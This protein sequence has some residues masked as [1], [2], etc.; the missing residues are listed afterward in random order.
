MKTYKIKIEL[1][2][3]QA[4]ELI[5]GGSVGLK[6]EEIDTLKGLLGEGR[7]SCDNTD[8]K[9]PNSTDI[10]EVVMKREFEGGK[11]MWCKNCIKRDND[12]IDPDSEKGFITC[13]SCEMKSPEPTEDGECPNC[14]SGN[15]IWGDFGE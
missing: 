14:R 1:T 12:M 3:A 11:V 4:T 8:C 7:T 5:N 2:H 10:H 9:T 15:W 6:A 13:G